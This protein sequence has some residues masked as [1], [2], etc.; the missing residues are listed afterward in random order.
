MNKD[1]N[2]PPIPP[3]TISTPKDAVIRSM[4]ISEN[5]KDKAL[6]L[7]KSLVSGNKFNPE[8]VELKAFEGEVLHFQAENMLNI[9]SKKSQRQVGGKVSGAVKVDNEIAAHEAMDKAYLALDDDKDMERQIRDVILNRPDKGFAVDNIVIP[10]N[11]WKKEFVVTVPCPGCKATGKVT[12][13]PCGGKGISPCPRCHGTTYISCTHCNGA[14]MVR[15][16]N[17]QNMQ[18]PI[19]HGRGKTT[20]NLCGQSGQIQ[21][22]TCGRRG[23]TP[24]PNC[25]GNAWSSTIYTIELQ[26]RTKFD[27]PKNKL[28]DKVVALIGKYGDKISED[29]TI[30]IAQNSSSVVNIDDQEKTRQQEIADKRKDIRI[31][32]LYEVILPYGHIEYDIGGKSYY[33][34]LFGKKAKLTHVSPFIDD[35]IKN[36]IRKL[37][38]AAENRGDVHENLKMAGEY[39]TVKEGIIFTASSSFKKAKAKLKKANSLGLSDSAINEIITYSD[40]AFKNITK[41]PRIIGLGISAIINLVLLGL[42]FLTPLRNNIISNISNSELHIIIDVA[43]FLGF[44]YIGVMVIQITA[45]SAIKKTMIMLIPSGIKTAPPKLGNIKYWNIGACFIIFFAI[46]EST[47]YID[48]ISSPDWYLRLLNLI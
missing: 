18:C 33:T 12:C 35:L 20:C 10:L 21:C 44:I 11:F 34:F 32:V 15:G 27:Y 47:R 30:N 45:E 28:P 39:R 7:I 23:T 48:S 24:C 46:I 38:D 41:K 37:Q 6:D 26:I 4:K 3:E 25:Q 14:Q 2:I 9:V 42:Y 16:P 1:S 13:L 36:G 31:P 40:K 5:Y 17:G 19:C 29:A 43:M 8:K 22:K